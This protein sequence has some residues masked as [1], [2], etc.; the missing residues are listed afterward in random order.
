MLLLTRV[1]FI[2]KFS[3]TNNLTFSAT[4]CFY[5]T[6]ASVQSY[7][8]GIYWTADFVNCFISIHIHIYT[9]KMKVIQSLLLL[10]MVIMVMKRVHSHDYK[11]A[12][13]KSILFFECQRSG[14][15]P[16]NQRITWR[17]DSALQDGLQLGVS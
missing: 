16:P 10:M 2:H 1:G 5:L 9:Q 7:C 17:K 15:L 3:E 14:K 4:L 11:E 6:L 12:L 8:I 13:S